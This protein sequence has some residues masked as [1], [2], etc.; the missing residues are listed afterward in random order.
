[1]ARLEGP[2]L[3]H[4][5]EN[6]RQRWNRLI[7][8]KAEHAE[9]SSLVPEIEVS[10]KSVGPSAVQVVRTMPA[11]LHERGILDVYLRALSNAK[12][13][14]YIEDQYFRSTHLSEALAEAARKNDKLSILAISS[15][16]QANHPLVGTWNH[17]CFERI[18]E[19]RPDF[20]L[21]SLRVACRD[22]RGKR[23]VVE[24]DHHGKLL[25][26]DDVF[27][28]VGSCNA[29]DRGFEYEGECNLAVY[30]PAL[31]SALRRE[32]F[33]DYLQR[34][35]RLGQSIERDVEIFR[36]HAER[37]AVRPPDVCPHPFVVPF[38]PKPRR[39]PPIFDR[40]VF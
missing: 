5:E 39:S 1:M 12:R 14:V 40:A 37:N 7:E 8:S 21:Y 35:E 13:L 17:A 38:A 32:L 20:S 27:L 2:A 33:C 10:T 28:S 3:A 22:G 31:V 15:E 9:R 19:V 11:P 6:F 23:R 34:D 4:L 26:V 36:E 29:N 25:I 30:D 18:K 24:V 16:A